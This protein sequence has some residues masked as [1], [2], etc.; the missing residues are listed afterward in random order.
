[1]L[2]GTSQSS[3]LNKSSLGPFFL[4]PT[5]SLYLTQD[6]IVFIFRDKSSALP[7]R[8]KDIWAKIK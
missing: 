7:A 3:D 4:F 6:E 2:K 8:I 1:M 5:S